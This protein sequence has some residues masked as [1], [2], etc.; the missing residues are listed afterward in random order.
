MGLCGGVGVQ[1]EAAASGEDEEG[2]EAGDEEQSESRRQFEQAVV[3]MG[4]HG[5]EKQFLGE[6]LVREFDRGSVH[7][8]GA[9][10]S[11]QVRRSDLS[12]QKRS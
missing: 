7:V 1:D 4:V 3:E 12:S 11:Y 8:R 10:D 9:W 2:Q 6:W 5:E